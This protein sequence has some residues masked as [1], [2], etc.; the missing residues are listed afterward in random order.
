LFA[1][2]TPKIIIIFCDLIIKVVR[3]GE[4]G[5]I[6][7]FVENCCFLKSLKKPICETILTPK[8]PL[9]EPISPK[10]SLK[11]TSLASFIYVPQRQKNNSSWPVK[12]RRY[13]DGFGASRL[14]TK[15]DQVPR[16]WRIM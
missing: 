14:S 16:S 9:K 12:F 1:C 10:K 13:Q 2:K 5:G 11:F 3:K 7:A 6:R 15:H 8:K 4:K